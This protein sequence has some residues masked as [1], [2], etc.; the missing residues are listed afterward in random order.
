MTQ[1]VVLSGLSAWRV[2]AGFVHEPLRHTRRLTERF[3][4]HV[5]CRLGMG[6][7]A[8]R[9]FYH[10]AEAS[11]AKTVF[12]DFAVFEN[13]GIIVKARAC[14]R[15][16]AMR[17]GYFHANGAEYQHYVKL[18]G[19]HFRRS[20]I[21][22]VAER[23]VDTVDDC[24]ARWPRDEA[25]D[26][27]PH[28]A[29]VM[30]RLASTALFRDPADHV[31][32]AAADRVEDHARVSGMSP[33]AVMRG[34]LGHAWNSRMHRRATRAYDALAAWGETRRDCAADRDLLS[35]IVNAPTENG[36]A[37]SRD[38][39]AGYAWTR[40]GAAY[41][42]SVSILGWLLVFLARNPDSLQ[43]LVDEIGCLS[44][45]G[46]KDVQ[47]L[48]ELPYL[49]AVFNEALRLVPP[50]V[51]QRRKAAD[52][53][54]LFDRD[55]APGSDIMVSAWMINRD[56]ELYPDPDRF[57]P[58]RWRHIHPAPHQ[59]LA[60]SAGPRRCLGIWYAHAFIKTILAR[61]L[62][63]AVPAMPDGTRLDLRML[64]TPRPWPG[65]P[66]QLK[67]AGTPPGKARL[68]GGVFSVL[69]EL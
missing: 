34:A 13:G 65:L 50:A 1:L 17:R 26:V 4:P 22:P 61:L 33:M 58:D 53:A 67:P 27:M 66:I 15:H 46:L 47:A 16:N 69:P 45:D 36:A 24:L 40:F 60:F 68:T 52:R 29:L 56:R 7:Y 19:P 31:G 25:F 38:R 11:A 6:G 28:L 63:H 51:I 23:I 10:I 57:D 41:D 9:S 55:I 18:F 49:D 35:A 30:K 48:M 21:D 39:I 62:R 12:S 2:A 64:L 5:E 44:D 42:T 43:R 54:R 20:T 3:G 59:W 32:L 14:P 8:R 37:V